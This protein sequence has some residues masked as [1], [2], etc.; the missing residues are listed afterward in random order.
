MA[1]REN[2]YL[3]GAVTLGARTKQRADVVGYDWKQALWAFGIPNDEAP[4]PSRAFGYGPGYHYGAAASPN[5]YWAQQRAQQ[6]Q[7]PFATATTARAQSAKQFQQALRQQQAANLAA[8]QR[9]LAALAP[10]ST[11]PSYSPAP[12]SPYPTYPT[13]EPTGDVDTGDAVVGARAG[14]PADQYVVI[15]V[16]N[17][18]DVVRREGGALGNFAYEMTPQTIANIAY[19]KMRD[20]FKKSLA[21]KGVDADVTLAATP[22]IGKPAK[23]ELLTGVLVGA[24]T[25]GIGWGLW[26]IV[27][28][29]LK[30]K[31]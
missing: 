14:D 16:K 9:Q 17:M 24:G 29:L 27:R 1:K 21:D 7:N 28:S 2:R 13:S 20:E 6:Q 15:R 8:L 19:G 3:V 4:D 5:S 22:P 12:S 23:G 18:G 30:T 26:H 31:R 10:S 25:V 11:A